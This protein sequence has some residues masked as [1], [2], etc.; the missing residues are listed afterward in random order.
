MVIKMKADN[1]K[2][3]EAGH[4]CPNCN[5]VLYALEMHGNLKQLVPTKPQK[6]PAINCKDEDGSET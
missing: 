1:G 4:A 6:K 2:K 3:E 5:L